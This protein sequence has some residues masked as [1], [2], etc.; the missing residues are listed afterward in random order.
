MVCRLRHECDAASCSALLR[1]CAEP[2]GIRLREF[3]HTQHETECTLP[4]FGPG[5]AHGGGVT[6][7][8]L[9]VGVLGY[10]GGDV[11]RALAVIARTGR[12]ECSVVL[13]SA[14]F[15]SSPL[16]CRSLCYILYFV[17]HGVWVCCKHP[18]CGC[19]C[20]QACDNAQKS[21][22]A[23]K[24]RNATSPESELPPLSVLSGGGV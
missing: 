4:F 5:G 19:H 16:C 8:G 14:A 6:I 1:L 15:T 10:G 18:E 12:A 23:C 3:L 17:F 7:R 2:V 13:M 21:Y 11:W 22:R 9:L 24:S 20:R